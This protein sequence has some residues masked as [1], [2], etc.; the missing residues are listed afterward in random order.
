MWAA[1]WGRTDLIEV[2]IENGAR[3][4]PMAL[5]L[6]A[7]NSHQGT[8]QLLLDLG[9]DPNEEVAGWTP[10]QAAAD[11]LSPELVDM[12]LEAGADP[13]RRTTDPAHPQWHN[14]TAS[15]LARQRGGAN[16][17]EIERLM[18]GHG[19]WAPSRRI[20]RAHEVPLG[21]GSARRWDVPD[22]CSWFRRQGWDGSRSVRGMEPAQSPDAVFSL[23]AAERRRLADAL[24]PLTPEEWATPSLCD[25]WTCHQVAAHL[26]VPF[27]VG[28]LPFAVA[29]LKARGNF[30]V[31]ND[32]IARDTATK[33]DPAAC[34]EGLR[35]NAG[36]R[37]TPPG[38]GP[39]AP[40]TDVLAHGADI[41]Q[42]VGRV[43]SA[44]PEALA[45]VLPFLV[46]GK[47]AGRFAGGRAQGLRFEATDQDLSAGSGDQVVRGPAY[48][49]VGAL[50]GRS[51]FAAD[52]EGEGAD[53][54]R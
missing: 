14:L 5:N 2:L 51:V 22:S 8:A 3:R 38:F 9:W 43:P 50:L 29:M 48:S 24:E 37:F 26:N 34:I 53:R 4:E 7:S 27:R 28:L 47:G 30:D 21:D 16:A 42:P 12:L 33:L 25:K 20:H 44:A 40:L 46:E 49:L 17:D 11:H 54:L 23:I 15:E 39:E 41:L 32:R 45:V 10:L 13:S 36:H 52:L 19:G 1:E 18:E 35:A 31:A 6:A